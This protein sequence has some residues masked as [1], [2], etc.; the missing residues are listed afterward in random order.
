[1]GLGLLFSSVRVK[2]VVVLMT[3]RTIFN[4][5]IAVT[6]FVY[7]YDCTHCYHEHHY[8]SSN[9]KPALSSFAMC[10]VAAWNPHRLGRRKCTSCSHLADGCLG[11]DFNS[12]QN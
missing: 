3:I 1:M 8:A 9:S 6:V 5:S 7:D 2:F 10:Y 4:I 12:P 11:V